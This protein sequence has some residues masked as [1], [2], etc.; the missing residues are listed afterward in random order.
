MAQA[1][2]HPRLIM[3]TLVRRIV[4]ARTSLAFVGV[5]LS[6][7]T[8][9]GT[10]SAIGN[11][12]AL[13]A[14]NDPASLPVVV[15]RADAAETT[16]KEVNRLLTATPTGKDSDWTLNVAPDPKE[17]AADMKAL[18]Q[19]PEYAKTRARVV[20]AEVWIRT[21][22]NVQS[23]STEHPNL[24]AAID[25]DLADSYAAILA[26]QAE[27]ASLEVQVQAEKAAASAD[28]VT[29]E[30]KKTHEDAAAK[31]AK[32]ESDDDAQV[33]PLQTAFLGK[34]KDA[35]AK[36]SP[37]DQKRFAPAVANLLQ[38]LDDADVANS[39]AAIKYPLVV[40][41]LPDAVKSVVPSIAAD[42]VEEQTGA[43]PSLANLKVSIKLSGGVSIGVD[44]LGDVGNLK[45]AD[46]VTETV[47][48][49]VKWTT[50][51]MTLLGTVSSTK[52]A[53]NFERDV[54]SQMATAFNPPGAPA[55][56][57]FK[58]PAM[59]SP[60]VMAA[61]AAPHVSLAAK[62]KVAAAPAVADSGANAKGSAKGAKAKPG[63]K[64]AVPATTAKK[65]VDP[66]AAKKPA[67]DAKDGKDG[68]GKD[69]KKAEG[70]KGEGAK[71]K[72]DAA[73]AK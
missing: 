55:V 25:Q 11:P 8:G 35:C 64:G 10:L 63:A 40:K 61:V 13:W 45:P 16:T 12:G 62:A 7:S 22:P 3:N 36:V 57:V 66:K 58:V 47:K 46:V 27:M 54:L 4:S 15:R 9:C 65:P 71:S 18:T 41:T 5:A 56:V 50:H 2:I 23:T 42:V 32:Q 24:L 67:V 60:E 37:D 68:G 29:P 72:S 38:A 52:H 30:D 69:D 31:L 51:A 70:T 48:R 43:R 59:N 21:L 39:A 34:V 44:G 53:I 17:A 73:A 1:L 26:K 33:A 6:T 28:G 49:S 19:D 14:I 20:A